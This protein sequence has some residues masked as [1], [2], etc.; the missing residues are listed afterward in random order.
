MVFD[1]I[2]RTTVSPITSASIE[3]AEVS[4]TSPII[5]DTV[6]LVGLLAG[7]LGKPKMDLEAM[8]RLVGAEPSADAASDR[9][10]GVDSGS[11]GTGRAAMFD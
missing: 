4:K 11:A 1:V 3:A 2:P 10:A 7:L 9:A 5:I 8:E 6:C